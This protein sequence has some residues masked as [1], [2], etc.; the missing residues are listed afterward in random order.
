MTAKKP[1]L[2]LLLSALCACSEPADTPEWTMVAETTDGDTV[3]L[4]T[5]DVVS[6]GEGTVRMW[7]QWTAMPVADS[8]MKMDSGMAR[9]SGERPVET[10][11]S[12][13]SRR[14]ESMLLELDCKRR[15]YRM[16]E[17]GDHSVFTEADSWLVPAPET[18][19]QSLVRAGC[20]RGT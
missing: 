14:R 10:Q 6:T 4:N 19:A 5:H 13:V 15:L 18:I 16:K 1:I 3:W 20:A 11:S 7:T 8:G 12:A 2:V 9:D 17:A